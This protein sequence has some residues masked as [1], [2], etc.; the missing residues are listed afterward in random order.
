MRK[1]IFIGNLIGRGIRWILM[2]YLFGIGLKLS[3]VFA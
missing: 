1:E 3:G 2:G